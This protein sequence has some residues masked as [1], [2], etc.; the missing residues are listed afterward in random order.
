MQLSSYAHPENPPCLSPIHFSVQY[1]LHHRLDHNIHH[2]HSDY[3]SIRMKEE[4]EKR[5]S[6]ALLPLDHPPPRE[7]VLSTLD[8]REISKITFRDALYA[9]LLDIV[10]SRPYIQTGVWTTP[11]NNNNNY[12]VQFD[13]AIAVYASP[14]NHNNYPF[15][16]GRLWQNREEILRRLREEILVNVK[17]DLNSS[18]YNYD[19][20]SL[21][22]QSL[23]VPYLGLEGSEGHVENVLLDGV[24]L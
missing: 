22:F 4:R 9:H 6:D 19:Y 23:L 8:K 17:I 2:H 7:D 10:P 11:N 13:A 21:F 24:Y 1:I 5:G 18:S 15:R 20:R 3:V 16:E 14:H 12:I